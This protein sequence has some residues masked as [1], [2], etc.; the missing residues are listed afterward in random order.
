MVCF[1]TTGWE[2]IPN[3]L[4]SNFTAAAKSDLAKFSSDWPEIEYLVTPGVPGGAPLD[5]TNFATM[6]TGLNAPL[7]RGTISIASTDSSVAPLI[8][9]A[10]ITSDTDAQVAVAAFKRA[11][12]VFAHMKPILLGDEFLPGPQVQTD[13]QIL[14]YIRK[15][16]TPIYHVSASCK[17]GKTSDPLAVV[18][19]TAKVIGVKNLRVV[20]AS[21]MPFLVPG[22]PLA[23]ICEF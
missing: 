14:A 2:K 21:A 7:S 12:A 4:R 5:G 11:R 17:M 23:T 15:T 3:P 20:D 18:D 9:P 19:N 13:A 1:V 10:W 8:N 6:S 16:I 22:H